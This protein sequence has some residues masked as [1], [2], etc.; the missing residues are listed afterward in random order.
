[1]VSVG[2]QADNSFYAMVAGIYK[3]TIPQSL[4]SQ[5]LPSHLRDYSTCNNARLEISTT[6]V[7]SFDP[8]EW[9][10]KNGLYSWGLNPG[11]FGGHE[12][13]ALTPRP[14]LL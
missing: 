4:P 8:N 6:F 12:F 2:L 9:C 11:P 14:R 1:M 3:L 5:S 13:S 10:L 7:P